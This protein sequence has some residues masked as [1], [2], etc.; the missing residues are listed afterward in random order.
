MKTNTHS[1]MAL[2]RAI[3]TSFILLSGISGAVAAEHA[4]KGVAE[5]AD[6]YTARVCSAPT[7][8][9]AAIAQ[10]VMRNAIAKGRHIPDTTKVCEIAGLPTVAVTMLDTV[11]VN[12]DWAAQASE[13]EL[14]FVLTHELG[15]VSAQDS[16]KRMYRTAQLTGMP[17]SNLAEL[18]EASDRLTDA[19]R[20][21][22][23]RLNWSSEFAADKF[24]WAVSGATVEQMASVLSGLE[25][26][27][28]A[29]HP[30]SSDRVARIKAY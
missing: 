29:T 8:R 6:A 15:H 13:G 18:N 30:S 22:L 17:F 5:S 7:S 11:V 1:T 19:D 26:E 16:V 9:T 4:F 21:E 28:S 2:V 10:V 23:R 3:F 24:A 12:R 14:R 27:E 25:D 20:E